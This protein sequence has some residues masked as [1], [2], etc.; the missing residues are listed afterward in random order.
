[1]NNNYCNAVIAYL[2]QKGVNYTNPKDN[3]IRIVYEC[4]NISTL[5]VNI[6][7]DEDGAPYISI[8]CWEI[9]TVKDVSKRVNAIL[10]CNNIHTQYRWVTFFLD[11][12]SD[13][14]AQI[15]AQLSL[16]NA[17]EECHTL[18]LRLVN[19]VDDVYPNLMKAIW[20]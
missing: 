17:G 1:M 2:D 19:I 15:D 8:R 12:D 9:S 13:I 16:S 5:P 18:V 3:H 20:A 6:Y 14:N 7:F 10:A 4:D 11:D